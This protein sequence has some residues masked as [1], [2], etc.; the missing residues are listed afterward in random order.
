MGQR[1]LVNTDKVI[2]TT[3]GKVDPRARPKDA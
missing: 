1:T 3:G 2:G